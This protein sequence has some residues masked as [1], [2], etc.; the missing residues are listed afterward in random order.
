MDAFLNMLFLSFF[1]PMTWVHSPQIYL[2]GSVSY[3]FFLWMNKWNK[4]RMGNCSPLLIFSSC[5]R[6][7]LWKL[8]GTEPFHKENKLDCLIYFTAWWYFPS[9]HNECRL[10]FCRNGVRHHSL[11]AAGKIQQYAMYAKTE[12]FNYL[13]MT[14]ED[15]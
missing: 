11:C 6:I 7:E 8:Y 2:Y 4:F 3:F 13:I 10:Q 12:N 1:L 9:Q 15:T 5:A 14:I